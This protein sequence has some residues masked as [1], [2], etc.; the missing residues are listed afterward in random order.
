MTTETIKLPRSWQ[1]GE[2]RSASFNS[3]DNSVEVIW[4]TG[5]PVRRYS[6]R[7]ES[8]YTEVLDVT[9]EAVD[10]GR[11]NSG[12]PL[13]NSHQSYSLE[14]VIGTVVPGSARIEDGKG[15]ARVKLSNSPEDASIAGKIRDGIIRN[16]SVG[17]AIREIVKTVSDDGSD[18][19]WR[20]TKW[21]PFELS[22]VP[23]PADAGAQIRAAA[24]DGAECVVIDK[25]AA[26]VDPSTPT[27]EPAV[28]TENTAADELRNTD[29]I[30]NKDAPLVETRANEVDPAV[31]T[32][33]AQEAV[34]A[35][36]ARAADISALAEQFGE[37]AFART[38]L[39]EGKSVEEFRSALL[40]HLAAKEPKTDGNVRASVGTE[41]AEKRGA[42]IEAVLLHRVD[43]A[44]NPL[45]EG[46]GEFRGMSLTDLAKE[47]LEAVGVSTRG[48]NKLDIA[49]E[50]LTPRAGGL[51]TT[52]DFT[53]ILGNTVARTLRAA[54]E[55]APQTFRPLVRET[56]VSD[57]K[58]VT[59]AQLGEAPQLEK[60]NE[61][62]EFKRGTIGEGK[63]SYKVTTF[64]KIVG[65]T[66]Q[67]LINDD[68]GAFSRLA[69]MF[70]VQAAQLESDLVWAEILSN[71]N[72]GDGKALF[73]ADHK[74]LAAA[75]AFGEAPLSLMRA[76][77]S[78]QVGID[79]KTV[80]NIRPSYLLVPV[81]LENAAEKLLTAITPNQTSSVVA[82]SI[83]SLTPISEPRIDNGLKHPVTGA[84]IAG[85]STAFYLAAAPGQTDTVELAYLE[86][87][88]GVYTES[89]M[90]FNTDGVEIKVRMDAGAK[91]IDWRAFQKNAGQ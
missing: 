46:A 38:F 91:V 12:A 15:F 10:L 59:R 27:Q 6:W 4:T 88:R 8:Y 44:A 68:L 29:P 51:H 53:V 60:V 9:P 18:Q 78:K 21:E 20:A 23:I 86:G 65:I 76:A 54:Y 3:E 79:G 77:M 1:P 35:E 90:G 58:T 11:L 49:A 66:R 80:L 14:S 26:P 83:R 48:M 63:E 50:A 17:Y 5:A 24:D 31:A 56:T 40:T 41:H 89:K 62:G 32:R 70:G 37:R 55:A 61:A 45:P 82:A 71:P 74:N 47:S 39:N 87:N 43:P 81:D 34:A 69:Q 84:A 73:H 42:V 7:D 36:R 75:A 25:R 16:I 67:A 64:G 85:S 28:A 22:A 52:A 72:M 19:E 33:A 30:V 2:V 13:L 57:F